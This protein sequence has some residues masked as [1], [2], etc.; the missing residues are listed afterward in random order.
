M[1]DL[2]R[3]DTAELLPL[4]SMGPENTISTGNSLASYTALR[5]RNLLIESRFEM[6]IMETTENRTMLI[7]MPPAKH[8]NSGL[9]S[10]VDLY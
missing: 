7:T 2:F 5:K 8:P 10:E 4:K 9:R 3:E 1:I 6:Q